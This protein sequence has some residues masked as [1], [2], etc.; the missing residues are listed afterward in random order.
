MSS[1][2]VTAADDELV[3]DVVQRILGHE[4]GCLPVVRDGVLV[5]MVTRHDLLKMIVGDPTRP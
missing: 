2:V 3:A 5:G 4:R 1:P